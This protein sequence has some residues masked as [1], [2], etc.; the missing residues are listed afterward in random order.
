MADPRLSFVSIIHVE[1]SKD[2]R[3]AKVYFSVLGDT[4]QSGDV[5]SIL[6]KA[7]RIIRK[8]LGRR[9]KMRFTPELTFK[10]DSSIQ[11]SAELEEKIRELHNES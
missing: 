10:Y 9:L 4:K 3:T 1:V 2:L 7:Q 6:N 11:F 5:E 8:E